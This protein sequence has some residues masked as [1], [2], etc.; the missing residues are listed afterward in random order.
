[1]VDLRSFVRDVAMNHL[2]RTALFRGNLAPKK[3]Y[4]DSVE[5]AMRS[6]G[7]EFGR[8]MRPWH[9]PAL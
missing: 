6:G 2:V 4:R 9:I 8:I 7:P 1:M 5:Q 3:S